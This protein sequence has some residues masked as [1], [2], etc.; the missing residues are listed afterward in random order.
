VSNT[1]ITIINMKAGVRVLVP[2]SVSV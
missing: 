2:W 1:P